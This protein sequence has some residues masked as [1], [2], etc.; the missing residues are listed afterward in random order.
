LG[1]WVL[2]GGYVYG[3]AGSI[4][5]KFVVNGAVDWKEAFTRDFW[6]QEMKEAKSHKSLCPLTTSKFKLLVEVE[7][8]L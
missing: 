6:G 4:I 1:G 3:D 5:K 7:F 8:S 2:I